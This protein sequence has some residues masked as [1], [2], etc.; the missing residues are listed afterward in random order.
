MDTIHAPEGGRLRLAGECTVYA[1]GEL[2][3]ALLQAL[4]GQP[5]LEVDLSG[6]TE[7]DSAALQVLMAAKS[8]ARAG[9]QHLQFANHSPPVLELIELYDLASWMGDPLI[10]ASGTGAC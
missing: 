6:I 9:G 1:A 3:A 7:F 2:K 8:F 5:D 10:V 4:Q